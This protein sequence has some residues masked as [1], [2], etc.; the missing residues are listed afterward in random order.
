MIQKS[1]GE[2]E[3][4]STLISNMFSLCTARIALFLSPRLPAKVLPLANELSSALS[5]VFPKDP[6]IVPSPEDTPPDFP[7]VV[8]QQGGMGQLTVA[9]SR[10]DLVI[11]LKDQEIW[12]DMFLDITERL[13]SSLMR[14]KVGISRLGLVLTYDCSDDVTIADIHERYLRSDK[15]NDAEEISIAWLKRVFWQDTLINRWVRLAFSLEP[16]GERSLVIDLNTPA[17]VSLNFNIPLIREYV[18]YW[19]AEVDEKLGDIIEW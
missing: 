7:V 8:F 18:S 3:V 14:S 13:V 1:T 6:L 9:R 10:S 16:T 4:C 12:Q 17:D 2:C 15:V 11:E 5:Y 19:F